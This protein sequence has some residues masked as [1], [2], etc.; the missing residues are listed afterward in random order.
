MDFQKWIA[1]EKW[2]TAFDMLAAGGLAVLIV[3]GSR[4]GFVWWA[5]AFF[6][7]LLGMRL[8]SVTMRA[9]IISW[10]TT[11]KKQEAVIEYLTT[12]V[13]KVEAGTARTDTPKPTQGPLNGVHKGRAS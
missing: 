3:A 10:M 13:E 8:K 1:R 4:V 9:R 2:E 5:S 7:I 6:S 12:V 11:A